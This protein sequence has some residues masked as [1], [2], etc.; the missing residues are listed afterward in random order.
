MKSTFVLIAAWASG[1]AFGACKD[2]AMLDRPEI[3]NGQEATFEE[4][5]EAQDAVA[6][7]VK[8]GQAFLNCV[9]P[10]PFVYNYVVDRLERT[11]DRF[12]KEREEYLQR[13]EAVAAN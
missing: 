1:S 13:S 5:L 7:Y 9:N 2:A 3:P 6:A 11:A 4:M 8:S 10:E 12:N